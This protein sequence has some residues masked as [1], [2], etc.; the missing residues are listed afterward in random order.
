MVALDA[1]IHAFTNP[2]QN[3]FGYT[4][5][6][7]QKSRGWRPSRLGAHS[8]DAAMTVLLTI[9]AYTEF[10]RE[11][12]LKVQLYRKSQPRH[13]G[14]GRHPRLFSPSNCN[15]LPLPPCP[16]PVMAG[17]DPAIHAFR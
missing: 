7:L 17:L 14:A 16:Q 11:L 12:Y 5:C 2:Q 6:R 9:S 4:F 10:Y 1:T 8:R 13:G 3:G 15:A